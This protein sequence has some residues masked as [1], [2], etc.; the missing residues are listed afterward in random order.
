MKDFYVVMYCIMLEMN[1]MRSPFQFLVYFMLYGDDVLY[2]LS[3]EKLL[4]RI[5]VASIPSSSF[6]DVDKCWKKD[7][8]KK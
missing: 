1:G 5:L 3:L 7:H 8:Y 4:T 6:L 2:F